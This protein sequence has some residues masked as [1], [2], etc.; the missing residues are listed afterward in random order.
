M[1]ISISGTSQVVRRL[2]PLSNAR[3]EGS[4]PGQLTKF[5]QGVRDSGPVCC[6]SRESPHAAMKARHS[7]GEG[8]K[9]DQFSSVVSDSF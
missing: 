6:N 3:A 2:N 5:P 9:K 7:Q 4:I 8:E 1:K